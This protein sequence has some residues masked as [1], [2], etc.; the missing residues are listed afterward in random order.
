MCQV[1]ECM[2]RNT[3]LHEAEKQRIP[4]TQLTLVSYISSQQIAVA[5]SSARRERSEVDSGQCGA[6]L[7]V[8]TT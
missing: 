6:Y 5:S 7:V 8:L 3:V 1:D 2:R 4:I